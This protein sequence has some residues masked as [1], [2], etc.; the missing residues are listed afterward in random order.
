MLKTAGRRNK[1]R[2]SKKSRDSRNVYLGKR[3]P[4]TGSPGLDNLSEVR[5]ICK[6]ILADY[7]AGRISK[8]TAN[9]RFS[10]LYNVVIPHDSKLQGKRKAKKIVKEYWSK[11]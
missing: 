10:L 7:R 8:R 6:A 1:S 5:G 3:V 4:D 11:L 2:R 9:G